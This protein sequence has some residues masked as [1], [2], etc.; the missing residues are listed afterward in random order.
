M[1]WEAREG[2]AERREKTFVRENAFLMWS[3]VMFVFVYFLLLLLIF[4]TSLSLD[5]LALRSKGDGG[6]F[7]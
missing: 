3:R 4:S 2:G 6:E 1:R 5:S 7:M